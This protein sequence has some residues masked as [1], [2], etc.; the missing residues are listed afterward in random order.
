MIAQYN[1]IQGESLKIKEKRKSKISYLA[2]ELSKQLDDFN[3]LHEQVDNAKITFR[4]KI[5]K[6]EEQ[7]AE[8][9]ELT[10]KIKGFQEALKKKEN[11]VTEI[12]A[13]ISKNAEQYE[14]INNELSSL[15]HK[16]E[17]TKLEINRMEFLK[18]KTLEEVERIS[19]EENK[20][21][22]I[23]KRSYPDTY[24]AVCWL[25]EHQNSFRAP[26][27]MPALISIQVTD[28]ENR[29]FLENAIPKR[30][31]LMFVCEDKQDLERFMNVMKRDKKL[32]V[33]VTMVQ[34]KI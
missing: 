8:L 31:L 10:S 24:Q 29:K 33:N 21:F 20:K 2:E 13:Q 9:I 3:T 7:K 17:S 14:A 6:K 34:M 23:L 12:K 30:D 5:T 28:E 19:S 16:M 27:S 26:I 4:N 1:I 11:S 18:R 22:E 32:S 25:Q 15:D